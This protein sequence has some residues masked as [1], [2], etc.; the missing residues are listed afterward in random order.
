MRLLLVSSS[1]GH[2]A[3]LMC[4]RSWWEK[5]DRH[6]V[7]FDT[8]DAVAKL[9]GEEVTWAHHPT[10]RNVR[11]LLRN[12]TQARRVLERTDPDVIVSTGA[13]VAVPYFWLSKW[14]RSSTVYLEV[15]DRI[16]TPTLTGRLCRPV[17]DLFLVQWEEQRRLYPSSVLVGELW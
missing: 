6:W 10:T 8:D 11:N 9:Q 1:G 13:A 3:Q 17:T 12:T 15:Y 5:H 14:R 7:T 2:L 16:E 4:L